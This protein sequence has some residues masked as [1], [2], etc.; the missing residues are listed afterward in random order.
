MLGVLILV[1]V[2]AI[3]FAAGYVTRDRISR[4]RRANYLKWEPYVRSGKRPA[5]PPAFL[6]RAPKPQAPRI[7][8]VDGAGSAQPLAQPTVSQAPVAQP[9]ADAERRQVHAFVRR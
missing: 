8:A 9:P 2:A 6:V 4:K 5:Q 1:L 3:S 7:S